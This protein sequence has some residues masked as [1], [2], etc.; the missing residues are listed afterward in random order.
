MARNRSP[1]G[2]AQSRWSHGSYDGVRCV[3]RSNPA[4]SRALAPRRSSAF[5]RSGCRRLSRNV[6]ML[7][8]TYFQRTRE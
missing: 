6:T 7:V 1:S 5:I 8:S 4:G 2:V 3:S